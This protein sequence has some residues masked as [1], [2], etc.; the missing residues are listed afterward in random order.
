M[1]TFKR[2]GSKRGNEGPE[3]TMLVT[4]VKNQFG[5]PITDHAWLACGAW[6]ET[7][8]QLSG[9]DQIAFEAKVGRY[10]KGHHDEHTDHYVPLSHDFQLTKIK[11]ARRIEP[12]QAQQQPTQ[13][14]HNL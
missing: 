3:L 14:G 10:S 8:G 5:T 4:D 2:Y 12:Q 9:G 1:A 6:S 7:L 13:A 11:A